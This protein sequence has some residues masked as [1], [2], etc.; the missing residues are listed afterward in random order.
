MNLSRWSTQNGRRPDLAIA[1][2]TAACEDL[3]SGRMPK[4]N[5]R[6][7][8]P[9]AQVSKPEIDQFCGWAKGEISQ[10]A[11]KKQPQIRG[12]L[13]RLRLASVTDW[14]YG[15][16]LQTQAQTEAST[17]TGKRVHPEVT[18]MIEN[19]LAS[20]GETDPQP[21]LLAWTNKGLK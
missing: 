21:I 8:H 6:L 10:L 18:A 11:R 17:G 14:S 7:L 13:T 20:Q 9:E 12:K 16:A 19:G 1:T 4:W 15:A 2:L 3:R 5:Y